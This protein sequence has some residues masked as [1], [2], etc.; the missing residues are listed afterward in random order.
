VSAKT[1]LGFSLAQTFYIALAYAC[2]WLDNG[3]IQKRYFVRIVDLDCRKNI[4]CFIVFDVTK[5]MI[6][7]GLL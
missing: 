7:G 6:A 3:A 5:F 2:C 4:G 1:L